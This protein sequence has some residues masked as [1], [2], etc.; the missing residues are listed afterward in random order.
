MW[1]KFMDELNTDLKTAHKIFCEYLFA[2][3]IKKAWQ[4]CFKDHVHCTTRIWRWKTMS[5]RA[6]F[7]Q[8]GKPGRWGATCWTWLATTL[9]IKVQ[10][11]YVEVPGGSWTPDG[12]WGLQGPERRRRPGERGGHGGVLQQSDGEEEGGKMGLG[13]GRPLYSSTVCWRL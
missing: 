7:T 9:A 3:S 12:V 1:I 5:R 11:F 6:P 10:G 4:N 8:Q 13:G 2:S